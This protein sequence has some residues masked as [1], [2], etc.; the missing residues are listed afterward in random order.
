MTPNK[1][2]L[3]GPAGAGKTA[4]IAAVSDIPPVSTKANVRDEARS[5]KQTPTEAM[6]RGVLNRDGGQKPLLCGTPGQAQ[7]DRMWGKLTQG[8]TWLVLL[9]DN[10]RDDPLADLE[11]YVNAFRIFAAARAMVV[12]I[13]WMSARSRPRL[14]A[15]CAKI[16]EPGMRA[17][18]FKVDARNSDHVRL[19]LLSLMT[20]LDLTVQS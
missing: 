3:A 6:D 18:V 2:I 7:F 17:P 8:G 14:Y 9:Q 12:G 4:T 11:L 20:M 1:V 15:V 13:A 5:R 16:Q 19:L 10:K